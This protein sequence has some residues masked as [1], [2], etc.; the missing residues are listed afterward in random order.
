MW[1]V[2]CGM[3]EGGE[4]RGERLEKKRR[5]ES[6]LGLGLERLKPVHRWQ[7]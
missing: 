3:C 5:V 2:A 4:K 1:H 7:V 6:T